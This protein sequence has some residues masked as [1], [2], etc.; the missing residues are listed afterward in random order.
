M[1]IVSENELALA[2]AKLDKAKAEL[3]L[4]KAHLQFTEVRA[5]FD[6]IVGKFE[7]VRLGSLLDEGELLTTL[8]DNSKMWVYFNVPEAEYLNYIMQP[9]NEN[10]LVY[11]R[12]ANNQ[13]FNQDGHI[14][15]IESDFNN[16]T[17][18][19][20]FRATF[21][22]PLGI[23]RHGQTGNI[24]WPK[25]LHE[26]MMIPQKATFE[27]LD[28]KFIFL[29]DEEG[30]LS[31]KEIKIEGELNHVYFVGDGLKTNDKFLLEGLRKVKAGEKVKI[32][33]ISPDDALKSL[34]LHAE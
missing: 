13:L 4:A 12:L 7:D 5:P 21:S 33:W 34:A 10:E 23:L 17:G 18:N 24:L 1:Q 9:Q 19:I 26:V 31:A 11:L 25:P 32:N 8:S 30:V 29:V 2:K 6:G 27:I 14:E 3:L 28:K 22:N 15:T 16:S 20:A